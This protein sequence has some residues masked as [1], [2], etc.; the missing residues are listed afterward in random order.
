M[1]INLF[2]SAP[3][4]QN[5]YHNIVTDN[6]RSQ[7]KNASMAPERTHTMKKTTVFLS[8]TLEFREGSN[9]TWGSS[10]ILKSFG[11]Y[12]LD[13]WSMSLSSRSSRAD[14]LWMRWLLY[15]MEFLLRVRR[16]WLNFIP[17]SSSSRVPVC[18]PCGV[19]NK[20]Y[21]W[22]GGWYHSVGVLWDH[23]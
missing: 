3:P 23:S 13:L 18:R 19:K 2:S 11:A 12:L 20:I 9:L 4:K 16:L 1:Q 7:T 22:A 14:A 5:R 15:W 17:I 6:Y 21:D 8:A 10:S